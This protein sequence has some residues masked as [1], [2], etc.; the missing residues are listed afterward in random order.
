M[1]ET[2]TTADATHSSEAGPKVALQ[3]FGVVARLGQT[4]VLIELSRADL[5]A[6]AAIRYEAHTRCAPGHLHR[7]L[8]Y[9][10]AGGGGNNLRG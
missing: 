2:P 6:P 3:P 10:G 8:A 1:N 4:A 7:A 9:R 5:T